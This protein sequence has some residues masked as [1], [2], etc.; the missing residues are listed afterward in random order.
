MKMKLFIFQAFGHSPSSGNSGDSS[1]WETGICLRTMNCLW[2]SAVIFQL[3]NDMLDANFSAR[4]H[5][6]TWPYF[7]RCFV[8]CWPPGV[9][10]SRMSYCLI[11]R[12]VLKLTN[13]PVSLPRVLSSRNMT[14]IART[15]VILVMKPK[16]A[17]P[18][19]QHLIYLVLYGIQ[20]FVMV[21]HGS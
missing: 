6:S 11:I 15:I 9:D 3:E 8:F 1:R 18:K 2:V 17:C 19:D 7:W 13:Q 21:L 14:S 4:P 12:Y 20:E 16:V 10:L 5:S